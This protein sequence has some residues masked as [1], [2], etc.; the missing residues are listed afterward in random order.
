MFPERESPLPL[1]LPC[2]QTKKAKATTPL[3]FLPKP[4]PSSLLDLTVTTHSSMH[5]SLPQQGVAAEI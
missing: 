1:S 2:L 3:G 4:A 5:A